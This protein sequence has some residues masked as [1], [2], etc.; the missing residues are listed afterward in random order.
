M[1]IVDLQ[2]DIE[3]HL[4]E[5]QRG[6]YEQEHGHAI[7]H[8]GLFDDEDPHATFV[9]YARKYQPNSEIRTH[10]PPKLPSKAVQVHS[11]PIFQAC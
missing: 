3:D 4:Q 9:S 6:L 1:E 10:T 8:V 2:S 7:E 11:H 5:V